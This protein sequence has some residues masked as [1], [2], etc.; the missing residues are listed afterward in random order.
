MQNETF[1]VRG[2]VVVSSI[3]SIPEPI[4]GIDM[5]GE[6]FDFK[7]WEVGKLAGYPTV[8]SVGNVVTG[9]GNIVASRKHATQVSEAAIEGYLGVGDGDHTAA[10]RENPVANAAIETA[11]QVVASLASTHAPSVEEA[12]ALLEKISARQREVGFEEYK[13]WMEKVG[14]P[15]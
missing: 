5:R 2:P 15:C 4:K 7:D 3:G 6:L 8:F 9:K 11:D 14:E 13:S 1:E 12:S 10:T